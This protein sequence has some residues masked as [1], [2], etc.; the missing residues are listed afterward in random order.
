MPDFKSQFINLQ[1]LENMKDYI[2]KFDPKIGAKF[3]EFIA[4]YIAAISTK[5]DAQ[6]KD[7][8]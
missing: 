8:G 1:S 3:E 5:Y 4:S 7:E 2:T 6:L